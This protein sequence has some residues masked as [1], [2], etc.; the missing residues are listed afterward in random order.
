MEPQIEI[1]FFPMFRYDLSLGSGVVEEN[2]PISPQDLVTKHK[3]PEQKLNFC[4]F[5]LKN[6]FI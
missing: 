5:F 6:R 3:I 2:H 1:F 4:D